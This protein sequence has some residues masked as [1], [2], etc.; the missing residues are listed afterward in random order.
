MIFIDTLMA[1]ILLEA[2]EHHADDRA[3]AEDLR[4]AGVGFCSDPDKGKG[5]A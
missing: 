1:D 3:L 5:Q 2:L 4:L